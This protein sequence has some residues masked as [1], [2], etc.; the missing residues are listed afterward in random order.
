MV[1]QFSE[2]AEEFTKDFRIIMFGSG[3]KEDNSPAKSEDTYSDDE[4]KG[5]VEQ[6]GKPL[7]LSNSSFPSSSIYMEPSDSH[8]TF[9]QFCY[10]V[11][12]FSTSPSLDSKCR[13]SQF[14]PFSSSFPF[15]S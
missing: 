2:V 14:F 7:V 1:S 15:A 5:S 8:R 3:S 13:A 9:T 4:K 10:P 12:R 6:K 11:Q